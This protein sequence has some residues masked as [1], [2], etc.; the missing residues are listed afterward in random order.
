LG[1]AWSR[2]ALA[3]KPLPQR[4]R[5]TALWLIPAGLLAFGTMAL[6]SSWSPRPV[7]PVMMTGSLLIGGLLA[8]AAIVHR[9]RYG[10]LSGASD[11]R[12]SPFL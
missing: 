2:W 5:L 8:A 4:S 1:M 11:A 12:L 3:P 6:W 9:L 7:A 10:L